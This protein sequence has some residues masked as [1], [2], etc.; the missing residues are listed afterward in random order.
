MQHLKLLEPQCASAYG[1]VP[2]PVE[3]AAAFIAAQR[4]AGKVV[5]EWNEQLILHLDPVQ[6]AARV[7]RWSEIVPVSARM[8]IADLPFWIAMEY[9]AEGDLDCFV[10]PTWAC[11]FPEHGQ[12]LLET[13]GQLVAQ[14]EVAPASAGEELAAPAAPVT[15]PAPAIPDFS[16]QVQGDAYLLNQWGKVLA[17]GQRIS[18][19][20]E[21]F[22]QSIDVTRAYSEPYSNLG[23]LLWQFGK[24]RE[25]FILFVEALIKNPHRL[26]GQLNF[27]DAGHEL[28][29]F[30]A[31]AK[32]I[33]ELLPTVH[34]Y[35]EFKHH[36]AICYFRLGR[37][38][39]AI[40]LLNNVVATHP[41][42]AEAQQLLKEFSTH[43]AE[44]AS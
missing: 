9:F 2:Q 18:E 37:M 34:E 36:L 21:A 7:A 33:E 43:H 17:Y 25:A 3:D 5:G 24:R 41:D 42:D 16:A 4:Q 29:E 12:K 14:H 13:F 27:F 22:R 8:V 11:A 15:T 19:A 1:F 39:E 23:A 31:M 44:S 20:G 30:G 35:V 26:A 10:T 40:A 38:D 6:H 28:A 32:V